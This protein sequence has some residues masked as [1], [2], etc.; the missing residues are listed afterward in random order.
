MKLTNKSKH[1]IRRALFNQVENI[2]LSVDDEY[3]GCPD[4]LRN[5]SPNNIAEYCYNI[6]GLWPK[7]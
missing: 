2:L 3:S 5:I 1:A 7:Q 6:I 4:I